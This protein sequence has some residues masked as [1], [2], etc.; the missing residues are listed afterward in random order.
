[1]PAGPWPALPLDKW[2]DTYS[3]LHM[4]TQVVGKVALART[5]PVNHYWNAALQISP[6]GFVTHP[7]SANGRTFTIHFN[8]LEHQL[9]ICD[10]HGTCEYIPLVPQTVADFYARV[11]ATLDTMGL[12]TKIWTMPVEV[13][14][15]IRFEQDT[16]HRAYD[17]TWVEAFNQALQCMTPVFTTSRARFLGKASP[18]HFFWGSFDLASSR[19]SGRPAPERPGADKM[20]REAYSHEVISHGF[21][22]GGG[23]AAAPMFYAYIAPAPEAFKNAA[24]QPRTATFDPTFSEFLLPYDDV[25][26]AA[27]P[28]AELTT[29]IESTY[30]AAADLAGWDRHALERS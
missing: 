5:P 26:L 13:P 6:Y 1:M 16:V 18:V 3:T 27:S 21:W 10:N 30:A 12:G 14:D 4:W 24:I 2:R 19:F 28:E 9:A 15:P 17:R 20:T 11:M 8:F 22:P 25:R 23:A 29:F 7:L